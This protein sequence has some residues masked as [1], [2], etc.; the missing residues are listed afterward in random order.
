LRIS[1]LCDTKID[2][3][4]VKI[5]GD[6]FLPLNNETSHLQGHVLDMNTLSLARELLEAGIYILTSPKDFF[7]ARRLW[8]SIDISRLPSFDFKS[9]THNPPRVIHVIPASNTVCAMIS[10]P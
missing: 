6:S 8:Q 3:K 7:I 2:K 4:L 9:P 1:I 10:Q 5:R